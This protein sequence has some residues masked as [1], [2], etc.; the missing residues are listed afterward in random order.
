MPLDATVL[1]GTPQ[2]EIASTI[3]R[4]LSVSINTQIVAG[5]MTPEGIRPVNP[6]LHLHRARYDFLNDRGTGFRRAGNG[7]EVAA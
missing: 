3:K 2:S 1:F 7:A 5:F 4:K 6:I